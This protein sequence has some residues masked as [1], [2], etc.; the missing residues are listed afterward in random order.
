MIA[1]QCCA[2]QEAKWGWGKF[3]MT[4]LESLSPLC[5]QGIPVLWFS[6]PPCSKIVIEL[7]GFEVLSRGPIEAIIL[8][9]VR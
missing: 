6:V 4:N 2:T 5:G 8:S 7:L 1:N 9:V 3:F